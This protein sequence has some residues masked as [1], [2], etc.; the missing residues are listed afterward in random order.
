MS[1][2]L[3]TSFLYTHLLLFNSQI[4]PESYYSFSY[5]ADKDSMSTVSILFSLSFPRCLP[6]APALIPYQMPLLPCLFCLLHL[7][8]SSRFLCFESTTPFQALSFTSF[9]SHQNSLS[10]RKAVLSVWTIFR[11]IPK[12]KLERWSSP[13]ST[14]LSLSTFVLC[15]FSLLKS[16]SRERIL[17]DHRWCLW[18]G[19]KDPNPSKGPMTVGAGE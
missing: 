9:L 6:P 17:I 13:L 12:E 10:F 5:F 14:R 4:Y 15:S 8:P 7:S 18:S 3:K 19:R 16:S 1:E 2:V 11:L